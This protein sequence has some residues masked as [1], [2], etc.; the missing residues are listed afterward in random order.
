[1]AGAISVSRGYAPCRFGQMHYL[2]GRP[3]HPPRADAPTLALLHQN[4]SSSLEYEPLLR[5]LAGERRVIAFDTPGYGMSDPPPR[6]LSMAAYAAAFADAIDAMGLARDAPVDVFGYHTGALLAAEL[7]IARPGAVGRLVLSG[8][9]M[10][11]VEECAQRLAAARAS[12]KATDDG[13]D[14]LNQSAALWRYVVTDRD[15]RVPLARAAL[16][17]A[18]KNRSLDRGWWAYEGVWTH[19]T[20]ARL[21]LITQPTLFLQPHDAL[22]EPTRRAR[23]LVPGAL[24]VELPGLERDI[25]DLAADEL[26][27]A[28]TDF[29]SPLPRAREDRP[30]GDMP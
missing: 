2:E 5:A 30:P 17:F 20:P 22:L 13:A 14:L 6:P 10:R 25:F 4:P 9:P 1:M 3:E 7:A 27:G 24:W 11:T 28:F 8:V 26:A 21:P 12:P 18:E 29:L 19:D 23:D 16:L 15:R